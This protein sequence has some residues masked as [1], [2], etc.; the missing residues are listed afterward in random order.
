MTSSFE[1]VDVGSRCTGYRYINA[2]FPTTSAVLWTCRG[3]ISFMSTGGQ[4]EWHGEFQETDRWIK[5]LF[6]C[7]GNTPFKPVNVFKISDETETYHGLDYCGR[8]V[9]LQKT[10]TY[11]RD[12]SMHIWRREYRCSFCKQYNCSVQSCRKCNKVVCN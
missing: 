8:E 3:Q 6:D 9:T 2:S 5:L 12:E 11:E 4:T 10:S 7:K 1:I